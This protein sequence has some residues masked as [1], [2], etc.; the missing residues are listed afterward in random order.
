MEYL[1]STAVPNLS[2]PIPGGNQYCSLGLLPEI[3][4]AQISH[5][6]YY[7]FKDFLIF[8]VLLNLIH[9]CFCFMFC[10]FG[11]EAH[12]ILSPQPGIKPVTPALEGE[13][14]TTG[15]PVGKSPNIYF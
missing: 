4:C 11:L 14:L 3:I 5:H 15:P 13:V 9:D 10:V 1:P 7:Y 2:F 12:G 6:I 8:K